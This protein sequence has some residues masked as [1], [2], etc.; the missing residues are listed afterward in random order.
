MDETFAQELEQHAHVV[1]LGDEN[2]NKNE[3]KNENKNKNRHGT[4]TGDTGDTGED[5]DRASFVR[6]VQYMGLAAERFTR[7]FPKSRSS[8]L[9]E[10]AGLEK[11]LEETTHH[12]AASE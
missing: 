8:I 11:L 4:N 2:K 10:M 9:G 6:M 1:W 7:P 3:N 5:R 12:T